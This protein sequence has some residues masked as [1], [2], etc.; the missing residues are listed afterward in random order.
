MANHEL[1]LEYVNKGMAK[2]E[3]KDY[4]GAIE[5]FSKAIELDSK[6][7]IV[8]H[9]RAE[10]KLHLKDFKGAFEDVSTSIELASE[11]FSNKEIAEYYNDRGVA[12]YC[13]GKRPE[14]LDD[15]SKAIE[16]DSEC[17]V[18]YSWRGSIKI[19]QEDFAGAI[20]DYNKSIELNPKKAKRY[21]KRGFA[22]MA[23]GK[24][25][26]AIADYSTSIE[27]DPHNADAYC[28]RGFVKSLPF[29]SDNKTGAINDF[30]KS[31]ELKPENPKAYYYLG[32]IEFD[33]QHYSEA[34]MY[35][36]FSINSDPKNADAYYHRGLAKLEVS[37]GEGALENYT[38]LLELK[39]YQLA[40][41]LLKEINLCLPP[42]SLK[43]EKT[44]V[45]MAK[46]AAGGGCILEILIYGLIIAAV[47][48]VIGLIF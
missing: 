32:R 3:L 17:E 30:N 20:D 18:A 14:A 11:N 5:D 33:L 46:A 2:F 23:L 27:L 25:H 19:E 4:K 21:S 22:K 1:A 12:N 16:L 41:S 47:I 43:L 37:N 45:A 7:A 44:E 9:K 26:D 34:I 31:I 42:K 36:T 29:F 13:L 15:F 39:E 38:K 6:D 28:E 40:S 48:A 10:S 8:Y 24:Y 35:F